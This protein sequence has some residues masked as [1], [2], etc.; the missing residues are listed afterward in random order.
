[1]TEL[2]KASGLPNQGLVSVSTLDRL[3]LTRAC[4]ASKILCIDASSRS[5]YLPPLFV[6]FLYSTLA[7]LCGV[8]R[9]PWF[10]RVGIISV[11]GADGQRGERFTA[12]HACSEETS[13]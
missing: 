11:S 9:P 13:L 8:A 1:M 5:G 4:V 10:G 12:R 7:S 6:S 3:K 2:Q